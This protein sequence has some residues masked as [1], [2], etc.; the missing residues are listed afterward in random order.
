MAPNCSGFSCSFP[1][2]LKELPRMP[3]PSPKVVTYRKPYFCLFCSH[4]RKDIQWI[5]S[6]WCCCQLQ[7]LFFT[8]TIIIPECQQKSITKNQLMDR[9]LIPSEEPGICS[10]LPFIEG[11]PSISPGCAKLWVLPHHSPKCN[12][13][14]HETYF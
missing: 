5:T 13:G 7:I 6:W 9:E 4:H 3:F 8:I 11:R 12:F 10:A 14:F 2:E 1:P